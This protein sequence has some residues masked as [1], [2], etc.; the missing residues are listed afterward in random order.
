MP[1]LRI[2]IDIMNYVLLEKYEHLKHSDDGLSDM[3]NIIDWKR[4]KHLL[5]DL[6]R[7][8]RKKIGEP[9][10]DPVFMVRIVF[11]Q[12]MCDIVD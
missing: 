10:F 1:Y 11:L 9:N 12:S 8:E 6:Y 5:S 2:C 7:N 4:N 3:N